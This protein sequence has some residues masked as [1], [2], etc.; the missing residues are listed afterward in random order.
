MLNIGRMNILVRSYG[1]FLL[2]TDF[3]ALLWPPSVRSLTLLPSDTNDMW[4][5]GDSHPCLWEGAAQNG[6]NVLPS[7]S[8]MKPY[9]LFN[10]MSNKRRYLPVKRKRARSDKR[11]YWPSKSDRGHGNAYEEPTFD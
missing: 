11:L 3:T 8:L 1:M 6:T 4:M 2:L 7:E 10:I 9:F 5:Q